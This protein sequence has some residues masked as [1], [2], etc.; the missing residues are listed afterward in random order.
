MPWGRKWQSDTLWKMKPTVLEVA[1]AEPIGRGNIA[2]AEC[3]RT[4]L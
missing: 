3:S 2:N 1:V 4:V